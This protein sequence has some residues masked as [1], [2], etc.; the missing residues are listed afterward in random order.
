L[1]SFLV[2]FI[3]SSIRHILFQS[4][5]FD[6]GIFDNGIYLISQGQTPFVTFRNLH[7]LG[8]HSAFILY[9]I[10]LFYVIIPSVY[11]LFF[12][13]ALSLS[14][15][16]VPIFS[17]ARLANLTDKKAQI[18]C[19]I[20]LLYPLIFNVNLFDF[21][22]EVISIPFI[23]LAILTAKL[24]Q[25]KYFILAIIII[26]SCKAVLSLTVFALGIWLIIC[27]NKKVYGLIAI[28]SGVFWFILTTQFII[29]KF[30]NGQEATAVERY[31]FLGDSVKEIFLNLF[32]QPQLILSSLFTFANLE[33]LALLFVPVIISLS[34]RYSY[35]LI[36]AIPTI[37]LNLITNYQ[38]H[39][40]LVH[41]YSLTIIPFFIITIIPSLANQKS[42]IKKNKYLLAYSIIGFLALAKY[43]YFFDRYWQ[44]LDNWQESYQAIK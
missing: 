31:A 25:L 13:Q 7:I 27:E 43:G 23:F 3:T 33:Y 18:V 35:N 32:L 8:D 6:L 20:Y 15:A 14:L 29:P 22:P 19:L 16:V 34:W 12:I 24:N 4:S 9:I 17:L 36:P 40:D 28:V 11:W 41:Q 44:Y 30:N 10:A 38:A 1:V 42:I 37:L 39:K 26:L 21:H 2:L 5:D